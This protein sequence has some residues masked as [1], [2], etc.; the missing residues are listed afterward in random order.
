MLVLLYSKVSD[1]SRYFSI[2]PKFDEI[3]D[4]SLHDV[5][6]FVRINNKML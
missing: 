3:I 6:F 2:N 4:I 1:L 5:S